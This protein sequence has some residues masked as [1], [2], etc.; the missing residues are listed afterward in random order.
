[1]VAFTTTTTTAAAESDLY[2]HND[3]ND[4][5]HQYTYK[6]DDDD[7]DDQD[8]CCDFV[9]P[10]ACIFQKRKQQPQKTKTKADM[11]IRQGRPRQ[12][13]PR[14]NRSSWR[15]WQSSPRQEE[16]Q[17]QQEARKQAMDQG[18]KE[19]YKDRRQQRKRSLQCFRQKQSLGK[20]TR[21]RWAIRKGYK[22]E[23]EQQQEEPTHYCHPE[24]EEQQQQ[25]HQQKCAVVDDGGDSGHTSHAHVHEVTE[26]EALLLDLE[27]GK[28]RLESFE[29]Y[30]LVSILTASASFSVLQSAESSVLWS[31]TSSSRLCVDTSDWISTLIIFAA[32]LST[33]CG[34][35]ATVVFSL[36]VL[37][38]KTAL[39]RYSDNAYHRLLDTVTIQRVRGFNTFSASLLLFAVET[40]LLLY[41]HAPPRWQG[42]AF[43]IATS[44]TMTILLDFRAVL[45]AAS[46]HIF[47]PAQGARTRTT[48][49]RNT[50]HQNNAEQQQ[51]LSWSLSSSSW[52]LQSPC[53]LLPTKTT[54]TRTNCLLHSPSSLSSSALAAAV[55]SSSCSVEPTTT[56]TTTMMTTP[57]DENYSSSNN[58]N[59]NE[60]T[61][62]A[63]ANT[64]PPPHRRISARTS[65]TNHYGLVDSCSQQ[66]HE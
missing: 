41:Q 15:Q 48:T 44:S 64:L 61:G 32:G 19:K 6:Y 27:R 26:E 37:Y 39:G 42:M 55:A 30:V 18:H 50:N 38:G 46:Q 23:E 58:N 36:C 21:T 22:Q 57:Q 25:Q 28:T 11:P 40:G 3:E 62:T 5:Y 10:F 66:Q 60:N 54:R 34:L 4:H 49:D 1:M 14:Q 12:S 33:I 53:L 59:S 20:E 8:L 16:Q 47:Q 24:E 43:F 52:L 35:H 63:I 65:I 9:L 45:L 17:P 7:D 29:S 31:D 13:S 56:T 51:R 2:I